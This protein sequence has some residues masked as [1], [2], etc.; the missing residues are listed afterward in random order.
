QRFAVAK[1]VPSTRKIAISLPAATT[2]IASLAAKSSSVATAVHSPSLIARS[3][4]RIDD[5]VRDHLAVEDD[6]A[7]CELE[8]AFGSDDDVEVAADVED[9][10]RP[11]ELG[12]KDRVVRF[13]LDPAFADRA[14][15]RRADDVALVVRVVEQ[16]LADA[17]DAVLQH[18]LALERERRERQAALMVLARHESVAAVFYEEARPEIPVARVDGVGVLGVELNERVIGREVDRDARGRIPA[19]GAHASITSRQ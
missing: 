11:V 9:R 17:V 7:A 12:A 5:R 4:Y 10:A 3:S 15:Q 18:P 2:K 13:A 8:A 14:N 19:R 1:T 6:G 16:R